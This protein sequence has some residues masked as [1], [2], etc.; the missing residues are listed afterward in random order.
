MKNIFKIL[1]LVFILLIGFIIAIPFI[2]KGKIA[3]TIKTEANQ[4]LNAVLN[5]S[6][7]DL[8]LL[9]TFPNLSLSVKSLSITGKNEFEGDT[10]I[11]ADDLTVKLGLWSVLKGSNISI[12]SISLAK[13]FINILVLPDGKANYNITKEDSSAAPATESGAY[14]LNLEKYEITD[15]RI[16]YDDQT[17]PFKMVLDRVFHQ[18]K[19]DFT[20]DLFVLSTKS[21]IAKTSAWYGGI[22]YLSGAK[23]LL[24]ADLDMDM[25][26]F[27]FTFK[28]NTLTVN[29]L[30]L[31]VDGW[32]AMPGNDIDM[33]LKWGVNKNEFRSF[34]SLIP[35]VYSASFK[36]VTASGKLAM[37]GFVKGIYNDKQ[38]PGYG[39]NLNID[40][41][42]FKYPGL[43][44]SINNMLVDLKITNPDGV[45]DHTI[46]DLKKMHLEMGGNPLDAR[47]YVT[48]PV[49]NAN[50]DAFLKGKL[51]LGSIKNM[52]P[53]ESGTTL[54]GL[55]DADLTAKGNYASIEQ[56]KYEAF[57]AAG[58]I[59]INDFNYDDKASNTS[60]FI[61]TMTM[62][63]N[64]KILHL[65]M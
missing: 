16:V 39:L 57:Y 48:N 32:L 40:K 62:L 13:P 35:G 25:K 36:D 60:A 47:L 19:G 63:F 52:I 4:N 33:D 28:E 51:N 44:Q 8:T 61:K 24:D 49:S 27:K 46:I 59:Q 11:Y 10:L 30:P 56:K 17:L 37:N 7:I 55:I 23:A 22:K 9:T 34:M 45:T 29:D 53:L 1:A 3:D 64:P 12:N 15:G 65:I 21:E 41:G 2:F 58:T 42:N 38:M 20:Q 31:H 5:F 50:I 14:K 54:N 26:N 43:P 18:G 6:D